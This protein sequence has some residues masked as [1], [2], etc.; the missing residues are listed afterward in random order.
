M[1]N[2]WAK[3]LPELEDILVRGGFQKFRA[4]QLRDYLYKRF[5]F[6]FSELNRLPANLTEWLSA[7]AVID[8]PEIVKEQKSDDKDTT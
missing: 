5:V 3:T 7:N 6:D 4:K 8:K 2:I 1:I